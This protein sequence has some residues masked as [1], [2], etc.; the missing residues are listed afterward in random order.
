[1]TWYQ[2]HFFVSF[3]LFNSRQRMTDSMYCCQINL[4]WQMD[5]SDFITDNPT[6]LSCHPPIE[7]VFSLFHY[8]IDFITNQLPLRN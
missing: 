7:S 3:P 4:A 1:M 5:C 2:K 6:H 8:I